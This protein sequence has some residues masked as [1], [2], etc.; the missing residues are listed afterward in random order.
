MMLTVINA[1]PLDM[2]VQ[3]GYSG[4]LWGNALV[5]MLRQTGNNPLFCCILAQF[6][7]ELPDKIITVF[8]AAFLVRLVNLG[9]QHQNGR[10][11]TK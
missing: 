8:T 4:N 3:D 7:I 9:N 10:R 6:F 2:I 11:R 5:D 1:V